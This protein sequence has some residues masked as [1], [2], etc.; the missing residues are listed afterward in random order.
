MAALVLSSV[1]QEALYNGD[2]MCWAAQDGDEDLV[3]KCMSE[4]VS[5]ETTTRDGWT[6][7][8]AA[9]YH[10]RL[11]VSKLLVNARANMDVQSTYGRTP[12]MCAVVGGHTDIVDLLRRAGANTQLK[13]A[14]GSTALS[15]ARLRSDEDIIKALEVKQ[16]EPQRTPEFSEFGTPIMHASQ[17]RQ[18]DKLRKLLLVTG[19]RVDAGSDC[20]SGIPTNA[21][22]RP[23]LQVPTRA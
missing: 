1:K 6:P 7:L 13:D 12:I 3:L 14:T 15:F 10:G 23:G 19:E 16:A 9:A 17:W 21:T 11:A 18:V 5:I 4:G 2:D 20:E 8:L 22:N